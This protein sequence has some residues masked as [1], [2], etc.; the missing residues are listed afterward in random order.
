MN[1]PLN[2]PDLGKYFLALD[3]I[4]IYSLKRIKRKAEE[5]KLPFCFIFIDYEKAFDSVSIVSIIEAIE[6][7]E[8][9]KEYIEMIKSICKEGKTIIKIRQ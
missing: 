9:E 3:H 8:R 1:N 2:K 4:Y 6:V 7:F 5:Y